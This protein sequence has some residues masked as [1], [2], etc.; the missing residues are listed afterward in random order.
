VETTREHTADAATF[1]RMRLAPAIALT[2]IAMLALAACQPD[3]TPIVP[4][5]APS[6]SPIFASDEEALAAAADA[7]RAYLAVLDSVYSESGEEA[8]ALKEVATSAVFDREL[9]SIEEMKAANRYSTGRTEF[10]TVSLQSFAPSSTTQTVVIYVCEDFSN[11]D[12]LDSTGESIVSPDRQI[13]W[14]L[15]VAFDSQPGPAPLVVSDI[16][17]WTGSDFCGE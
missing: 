2:A 13:R 3:A 12:I 16:Q 8:D 5:P 7:Y 10:D 4:T 9:P 11:T 1:V 17:D 6:T 14:P 15:T